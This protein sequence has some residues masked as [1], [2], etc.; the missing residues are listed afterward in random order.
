MKTLKT[1]KPLKTMKKITV[2]LFALS[3]IAGSIM[4][5]FPCRGLSSEG[6]GTSFF[7]FYRDIPG[8]T[9]EQIAEIEAI[10]EQTD[11]F[12]Y[13][14]IMSTESF[15]NVYGEL[16]GFA[17]LVCEWLSGLFG[18]PFIPRNYTREGLLGGLRDGSI[19]FSGYL[20][21][22]ER[23]RNI[24]GYI[25]TDPIAHRVA[26][27]F[28]L[29]GSPPLSEIRAV[30]LP[31]YSLVYDAETTHSVLRYAIGEFEPVFVTDNIEAYE[32]LKTGAADAHITIGTAQ[33][34]F[35]ASGD[36]VTSY[37]LPLIHSTAAFATQNPKL[38]P[39]V[40]VVQKAL[41]NGAGD[42][43]K[44]L[45]LQG[46]RE[47]LRHKLFTRLTEE[48]REY[49][50]NNPVIRMGARHYNYPVD[51]YNTHTRQW[52]GITFDVLD[53]VSV[54]TGMSFEVVTEIGTAWSDLL[55]LLEQGEI[56]LLPQLVRT[57]ER[58]GTYI[59]LETILMRAN[60][61][62]ISQTDFPRLSLRDIQNVRVAL[63]RDYAHT[64]VFHRLFPNH[65]YNMEYSIIDEA[66][67]ALERGEA[68][69]FMG[70]MTQLLSI[71]NYK[72]RFGF[73][74][75]LL[76][77]YSYEVT[78][79]LNR[80]K[81][82]LASIIDKALELVDYGS[83]VSYWMLRSL[84]YQSLLLRTQRPWLI[85]AVVLSLAVLALISAFLIK[86]RG[87]EKRLEKLVGQRTNE[88]ERES[89]TLK[90]IFDSIPDMVF[91][92][93][94]NSK[95][96]RYNK[97][98]AD[99]FG[100]SEDYL[101]G[102][103][104][105]DGLNVPEQTAKHF[106][107]TDRLVQRERRKIGTEEWLFDVEG[108]KRFVETVKAPIIQQGSVTGI[109]GI[110]R[111]ITKHK[112]LEEEARSAS[113]AKSDFLAVMSHEIR[114]P[115]NAILGVTEIQLQKSNISREHRETFNIIYNASDLLLRIINDLLDLSK[116]DANKLELSP[117]KYE[118]ASLIN[119]VVT[120]NLMRFSSTA[121]QFKLCVDENLPSAVIGDDI[122]LKQILS[123]LLSNA[124]K[125]TKNGT[126]T[127]SVSVEPDVAEDSGV[128]LVFTVSD[129]G[130]GMTPEQ[131]AK[132]FDEYSRFDMEANRTTEGTG[133]GMHIT[134]NLVRMM[135]GEVSVES[136]VGK[137][138]DV[139]VR[140]RQGDAG[141]DIL[142]RETAEKLMHLRAAG[143]SHRRAHIAY[144][145]MPYGSVLIV[146]D[147]SMNLYVAKGLLA[148]YELSVETAE[149]GLEAIEKIKDGA[150]YDILFMDYMMPNMDG[151]E[152][153]KIIR[154]LGYSKP[155]VVLTADAVSGREDMFIDNG[156]DGFLSKPI[157]MRLMDAVLKKF[158]R[159]RYPAQT[160]EAARTP[161]TQAQA[162]AQTK[163]T[164]P[165]T[166][167]TEEREE[168]E[169]TEAT[170]D[171]LD[172]VSK[173]GAINMDV[174]L[175]R[176]A[177]MTN[178]Y[179]DALK[180]FCSKLPKE[181]AA[182]SGFL[183]KQDM[184]GFAVSVHGMKSQLSTIGAMAQTE[185]AQKLETASKNNE[186][187]Y[188]AAAFPAFKED[189][190]A[191]HSQLSAVFANEPESGGVKAKE[192]GGNAYLREHIEKAVAACDDFDG[193]TAVE[194]LNRLRVYDYGAQTGALIDDAIAALNDF[195]FDK[196]AGALKN[197][198]DNLDN[199][200][201]LEI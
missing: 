132:L 76:L 113:R 26:K 60:Y 152:A 18:I 39:F 52:E 9:D 74:A 141:S 108:K 97:V 33:P 156:F 100:V 75:N 162:Q 119:D 69:V 92:K 87:T 118:T 172:T 56:S 40:S 188:C 77:D 191:I 93:D 4:G 200:D 121:L 124:F 185:T 151:M 41:E 186:A 67:S 173:I 177:G 112:E 105:A 147:V 131:V 57:A 146:D 143:I 194:A 176:F 120:I 59:W 3:V 101:V 15:Y 128:I 109:I 178:M 53:E 38:E 27:Y 150:V 168:R 35:E 32:L 37:F 184:K 189:L 96:R 14:M 99:F 47:Y 145:P 11:Y 165:E 157:D 51:F 73:H 111:D 127:F 65:A 63:I 8:V 160:V 129:T 201:I 36:I 144:E 71:A 137:G 84:D 1:M 110:S 79:G 5:C 149:S 7:M 122:R 179:Y 183:E 10:L 181:C 155:I 159:N 198:L 192:P 98:L 142:G 139:T 62:F 182:M 171:F 133:L 49:I 95:Y 12:I 196:T 153:M 195:D 175:S 154:G 20:M 48:E 25:M 136:E 199:L 167:K 29:A 23:R 86:S 24:D 114:T 164:G 42:F 55:Q 78:I 54:L 6:S 94:L 21:P 88:L 16:S 28:R 117:V 102:K 80:D 85:G 115:M 187:D 89:S 166:E 45:Y 34:V 174:G 106:I 148:P 135:N 169:K 30:R 197:I 126:V 180:L 68:D 82:I 61:L 170:P 72:E 43:L 81:V 190:L 138:T 58:E 107:E 31:R 130:L 193:D 91:C 116:I 17:A 50:R 161:K 44:E 2:I 134:R 163:E 123:N 104:D 125:Y 140:I 19:D 70:N 158:I 103:G 13:G 22:T 46:E 90:S 66:L 83:I 64:E